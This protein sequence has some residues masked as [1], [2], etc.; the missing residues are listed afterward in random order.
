[1]H[2]GGGRSSSAKTGSPSLVT[3]LSVGVALV[4]V[5]RDHAVAVGVDGLLVGPLLLGVGQA[6]EVQLA[7]GDHDVALLAVDRVAV[8][9]EHGGHAVVAAHL[10][11]LVEGAG[12]QLR[13]DAAGCRAARPR[14]QLSCASAT[15]W[16]SRRTALTSV[17]SRPNAAR[18]ASMFLPMY[19][20]SL[21]GSSGLTWNRCIRPGQTPRAAPRRSRT[22]RGRPP[23][24]SHVRRNDVG[25]EQH[26]ADH[27]DEHQ[28]VLR[29]QHGV[30]AACRSCR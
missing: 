30:I 24:S 18:V 1:M 23:G 12:D 6:V 14:R 11:E 26:R 7:R 25:E 10:L 22:A 3:G 29:R 9:V 21:S 19:D 8:D 4:A 20:A 5:G 16:S 27:R 15:A 28:D 17:S 13:V 2:P